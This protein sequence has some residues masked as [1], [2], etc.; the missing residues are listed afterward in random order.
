MSITPDDISIRS[1]KSQRYWSIVHDS[2]SDDLFD[3]E[4][5]YVGLLLNRQGRLSLHKDVPDVGKHGCRTIP[6]EVLQALGPLH[7]PT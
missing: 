3:A 4:G 1:F 7:S 6:P 5:K 2:I